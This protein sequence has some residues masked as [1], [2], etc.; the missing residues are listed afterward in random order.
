MRPGTMRMEMPIATENGKRI[1]GLVRGNFILNERAATASL[2]DR[3]HQGYLA[4]DPNARRERDDRPR[5][6]DGE[7]PGRAA[8]ALALHRRPAPSR[9]TAVSNRDGSTTSSTAPPTRACSAAGWRARAI[10]ISFLKYDTS[11]DNPSPGL[12]YAIGWG[13][14][15]SGR[16]LRHFLYQGFNADEQGR[17]RLRR[18]LRSG[19][20]RGPRIVQPPVRPGVAR[21]AA[22]SSTSSSRWICFRSPTARQPIR[23]PAQ[24]TACSRAR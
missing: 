15:Q 1:F 5:R 23:K 12:K 6:S 4:I 14:S 9:S 17:K 10:S 21:C 16:F 13:V 20:R 18:R 8:I 22:V 11:P 3:N 24:S 7:G 19:R 2:A